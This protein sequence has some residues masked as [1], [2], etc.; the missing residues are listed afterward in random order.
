MRQIGS[1]QGDTRIG[2]PVVGESGV[3]SGAEEDAGARCLPRER[4]THRD[5]CTTQQKIYNTNQ[6]KPATARDLK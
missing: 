3:Q 6:T 4:D 1:R 5:N 2:T